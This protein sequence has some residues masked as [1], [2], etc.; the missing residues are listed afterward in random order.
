MSPS[1]I[2]DSGT[3]LYRMFRTHGSPEIVMVVG[4]VHLPGIVPA[5]TLRILR[6][7]GTGQITDLPGRDRA[8]DGHD[9]GVALVKR[10]N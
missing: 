10:S 2:S 1:R 6:L 9:G 7:D 5:I 8:R 4:C 3:C